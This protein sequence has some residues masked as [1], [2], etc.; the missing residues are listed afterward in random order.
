MCGITG[1]VD[2]GRDLRTERAVIA[3]MTATMIRRGPDDGDVWCSAHAA[4]GHRRLSVIDLPGGEQPMR[5]PGNDAGDEVAVTFS[6]EIYNFMELRLELAARGHQFRTRSDTEVL[7]RSYLEWGAECVRRLN[8]M[9]A[10]GI[11]DER[12]QELLLARD[13][14]GV[15]P[16]YYAP[17]PDGVL[18]GSEPKAILAHPEFRAEIDAEGIAELFSQFG[19]A[20]PGHGVYRGLAEVRPGTLVRVGRRGIRT[21]GYWTLAAREHADDLATTAGTVRELLTDIVHRQT[22]A[23]VPLC[24]LLSGGLD[25]S[26]VSALAAGTL[27]RRNGT[28]LATFSVDFAGSA[29]AFTPDPLRPSHDEPFARA[30]ADY[31]G[32]RHNTITL[33]ADD[34][35]TAQWAPLAAHDLPTTMGDM[36]VSFGLLCREISKQSTVA[37]SGEAADEVFGGYPW[38]HVP[39]LLAAPTFPW[40][41]RGSW[42]PLLHPDVR[43]RVRLGEYAA[44]RY[45][46]ALAEVPRLPGES[47]EARRVREVLYLGLTRWL[48]VLL[49]RKDRL[50][51][52]SGLEVRV[53]F[54]D[55]RLVEYVWNVPWSMKEA[56]GIEKGLLRAAADGLLPGDLLRRRKSAYPGAADPAYDRVIDAQLRRLLTQPDAPLFGLISRERLTAA[57]AADPRL[58]GLMSV[59]PSSTSPVAYLLDINRWLDQYGVTIR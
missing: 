55:H 56:G 31:I 33:E 10:F 53:P 13:R 18:F 37:L 35:V 12:R 5:A 32:A 46:Q 16:L 21:S 50:S 29:G 43:A 57:Y 59:Q 49:N 39:A 42:E 47:R 45:T 14:L 7:L 8:G 9:F 38:Y 40:A 30:A 2:F 4:I 11:W 58:P 25:S 52:A 15:K 3:T 48:P 6:G 54:C 51:M 44:D 36:Y 1:W 22:V 19:T 24:S 34:L 26:V 20:T 23:D 27:S 28:K 41:A 17:R